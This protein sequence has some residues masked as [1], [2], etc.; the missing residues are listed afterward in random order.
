MLELKARR[1]QKLSISD[2]QLEIIVGCLLGDG[3]IHPRGQIQIA[4]S[5]KQFP[6][7]MWKYKELGSLA[8][9]LPTIV[10]RYDRRYGK[11]YSQTRF[12]LRQFFRSWRN[13]FYPRGNKIFPREF[14]KYLTAL[15]LAVWF[16]DDGNYSES[17]NV[18]IATDGFD[19]ETR[20]RLRLLLL[21]KF[22]L[23]STLHKN[24]KLRISSNSLPRFFKLVKPYIHSSMRYKVS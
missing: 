2:R 23:E 4:H 14:E 1:N 20:K 7:V 19:F 17:R 8:Y 18:K 12:W 3:Y 10:E 6:Y 22:F 16:M 13:L 11:K 9:G 5:S 15:S 21:R 24:G